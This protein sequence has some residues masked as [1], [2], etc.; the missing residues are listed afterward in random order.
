MSATMSASGRSRTLPNDMGR[1]TQG[2]T[3]PKAST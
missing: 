2:L 3:S 1:N